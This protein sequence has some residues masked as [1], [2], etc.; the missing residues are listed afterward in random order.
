MDSQPSCIVLKKHFNTAD[1]WAASNEI[2]KQLFG[3][4]YKKYVYTPCLKYN[5]TYGYFVHIKLVSE[6][7]V[8]KI[9]NNNEIS[10]TNTIDDIIAKFDQP[11]TIKFFFYYHKIW[12][13]KKIKQK[14]GF[15]PYG[16]SLKIVELEYS[17]SD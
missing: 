1:K 17:S 7:K 5:Q 6:T 4:K 8:N 13:N 2:K 11:I 15:I 14:C 3:V 12:I 9:A 16:L 10:K